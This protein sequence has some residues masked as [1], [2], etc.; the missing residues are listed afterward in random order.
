MDYC[1]VVHAYD[2]QQRRILFRSAATRLN[3]TTEAALTCFRPYAM[4]CTCRAL[5]DFACAQY[6]MAPCA[7]S[8]SFCQYMHCIGLASDSRNTTR[9]CDA[10]L[11]TSRRRYQATADASGN[12]FYHQ[13]YLCIMDHRNGRLHNI[14]SQLANQYSN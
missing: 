4:Q 2:S 12:V 6:G 9:V 7:Q 14:R 10:E 8:S 3:T 5:S 11:L 13:S 1:C